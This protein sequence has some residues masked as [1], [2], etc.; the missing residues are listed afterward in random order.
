[1]IPMYGL[2]VTMSYYGISKICKKCFNYHKREIGCV[3]R[4]WNDYVSQFKAE[5]GSIAE[6]MFNNED[7]RQDLVDLNGAQEEFKDPEWDSGANKSRE[8]VKHSDLFSGTHRSKE[9]FLAKHQEQQDVNANTKFSNNEILLFI[10]E[11][12]LSES[13]IDWL[14]SLGPKSE[15]EIINLIGSIVHERANKQLTD[16]SESDN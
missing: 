2:R 14:K 12:E 8:E 7:K 4:R 9:S 15:I 16:E 3:K 5:N 13:E 1:M 11:N 10:R 6:E